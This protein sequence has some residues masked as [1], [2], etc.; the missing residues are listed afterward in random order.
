MIVLQNLKLY[1]DESFLV[2]NK[3]KSNVHKEN[4]NKIENIEEF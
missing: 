1:N 2:Q 3:H 4:N